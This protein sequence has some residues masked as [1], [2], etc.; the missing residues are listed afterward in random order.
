M[1]PGPLYHAFWNCSVDDQ[2][3]LSA[4]SD[5][6]V[7]QTLRYRTDGERRR[8]R[9]GQYASPSAPILR[10]ANQCACIV[11]IEEERE[12][13]VMDE[14]IINEEYKT[15]KKNSPFLYDLMLS[16]ALEWPTLTTQWLPD[17]QE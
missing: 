4:R 10:R 9:L 11:T 12:D 5:V 15:W 8:S 13:E 7:P 16:N 6:A 2:A 17:K 14:K 3:V 1:T